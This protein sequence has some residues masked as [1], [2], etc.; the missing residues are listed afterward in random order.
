MIF[1][2]DKQFYLDSFR[3]KVRNKFILENIVIHRTKTSSC[4]LP[5]NIL[6]LSNKRKQSY[7]LHMRNVVYRKSL[8]REYNAPVYACEFILFSKALLCH[9]VSVVYA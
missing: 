5:L 3:E 1:K 4:N 2:L 9:V 7:F 6:Y 8:A